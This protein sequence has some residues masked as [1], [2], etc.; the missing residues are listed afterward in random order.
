MISHLFM[1][2]PH[3]EMKNKS[4]QL[5]CILEAEIDYMQLQKDMY[6]VLSYVLFFF[7]LSFQI[8]P[9]CPSS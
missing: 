9:Q 7:S 8:S 1:P 5:N 3:A 4:W 2:R 6:P